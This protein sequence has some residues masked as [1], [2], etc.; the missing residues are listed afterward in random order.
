MTDPTQPPYRDPS[1]IPA[2]PLW[3]Q[4]PVTPPAP[5]RSLPKAAVIV[6]IVVA[7]ICCGGGAAILGLSG[8]SSPKP[9]AVT[10]VRPAAVTTAPVA[11]AT[12]SPKATGLTNAEKITG[13]FNGGGSDLLNALSADLGATGD[14]ASTGDMDG[15]RAGCVDLRRD[16]GKAK[17]YKPI[18]VAAVQT[19]W[20]DALAKFTKAATDCIN[21][22]DSNSSTLMNRSATELEAGNA[23]IQQAS[24]LLDTY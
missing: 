18:P 1:Y 16:V 20:A 21:G 8:G 24:A 5:K 12:P 19:L 7:V 4:P 17:A 13:W 22:A 3:T 2:G 9:A 14:A 10:T 15:T 23:D 6:G 11:K